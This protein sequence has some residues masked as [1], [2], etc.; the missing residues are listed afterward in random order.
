MS[1]F[2]DTS[3]WLFPKGH[4]EKDETFEQAAKREVLEECSII[5]TPLTRIGTTSFTQGKEEVI[6]EW[7]SG[8]AVRKA[9]EEFCE[10]CAEEDFR[11]IRWVSTKEALEMLSFED[12]K[13]ILKRA[14]C[15]S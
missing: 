12:L 6:V 11:D 8:V 7:W 5:A 3:V 1:A 4:L 14:L 10:G 15:W 9:R 13:E 2:G